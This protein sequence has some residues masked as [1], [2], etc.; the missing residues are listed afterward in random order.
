MFQNVIAIICDC[1]GTLCPDTTN[2]LVNRLGLDSD[3]FWSRDVAELVEN[4]WDPPLAYLTMLL[5]QRHKPGAETVTVSKLKTIGEAIDFYPGALDF[6][7][8]MRRGPLSAL[9]YRDSDISLEWYIV[10][11]GIEDLLKATPLSSLANDV[12]GCALEFDGG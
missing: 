2:L 4:G 1:D 3:K 10:S 6:V 8:R 11:S 7:D 9:E 5:E 12:F